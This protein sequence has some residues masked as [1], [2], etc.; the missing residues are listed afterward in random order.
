[1]KRNIILIVIFLAIQMFSTVFAQIEDAKKLM[2]R[3]DYTKAI[4]V[5]EKV[6]EK[7]NDSKKNEAIILLAECYRKKGD[8]FNAKFFYEKAVKINSAPQLQF[9]F[10]QSLRTIG[11]YEQAHEAFLKYNTL[12]PSD[13]RGNIYTS[14]CDSAI[15][16]KFIFPKYEIQNA[17]T[18]NSKFSEFSPTFFDAKLMFVSDRDKASNDEVATK[19]QFGWTG[20][21][22]LNLYIAPIGNK[23]KLNE[24]YSPKIA[25]DFFNNEYHNGP[26]SFS[27]N[28]SLI[29]MNRTFMD[30]VKPDSAHLRTHYLKIVYAIKDGNK[31]SK[32]Q[33]FSMNSDKYSVGHPSISK[34]GETIFFVSDKPGGF[35]GTDIYMCEWETGKWSEATNLGNE[36][37]TFGNEMF[38]YIA[39]NGD[40]YFS[41]DGLPG[42]GSLDIFVTT[43]K[44]GKW[45]TPKNLMA[46]INSSYDDFSFLLNNDYQTGLFS[47]NRPGGAGND[48]IYWFQKII[49]QPTITFNVN[50]GDSTNRKYDSLNLVSD[51]LKYASKVDTSKSKSIS[52]YVPLTGFVKDKLTNKP[53]EGATIFLLNKEQKQVS[54]TKSNPDGSFSMIVKKNSPSIIKAM[55]KGYLDDYDSIIIDKNYN[56]D[57][58]RLPHNL[59]LDKLETEK[60]FV[61]ENIYYD[62]DKWNIRKD[63][64]P[65]LNNLIQI[66][67]DNPIRIELASHT[68]CRGRNGYNDTLSQKRAT[69][70]VRYI[71]SHGIKESRITPIGYGE[72]KLVNECKDGVQCSEEKHQQNRRTEFKIKSWEI[73][74]YKNT[75]LSQY[76][77]GQLI[78]SRSFPENF[79][80]ENINNKL[81]EDQHQN[82]AHLAPED[83]SYARGDVIN[84][85]VEQKF[86]TIQVYAGR[87][88]APKIILNIENI[89]SC[90]GKD[91][92]TRYFVGK[93][94][95]EEDATKEI[96][97][98]IKIGI[99]DA[100]VV[101]I[102]S[103][104]F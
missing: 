101:Q 41:S 19:N 65:I 79:F 18:L 56:Q 3:Y 7:N 88:K 32:F 94:T 104:C 82:N 14:F 27:K 4:S 42:F 2:S 72:T 92:I 81:E 84:K 103:L 53:I 35:G 17:R 74:T 24:F 15:Q 100:F 28:D 10:A 64:E 11:E 77:N 99:K 6:F 78:D 83:I 46:P 86:Y 68:D 22:Y 63:A 102:E 69:S 52:D 96:E 51:T 33:P 80:N 21:G 93:Y 97:K 89:K 9:Y 91:G 57:S 75:D 67:K 13:P 62:Y 36:I 43:Q 8:F 60:S 40:L 47:S 58:F 45:T 90:I 29:Y 59:E 61:L 12:N 55:L 71:V 25:T 49:Q 50:K 70:A 54:I 30:K 37:N 44:K 73:N 39:D 95:H 85:P 38:P 87:Y 26:I 66:M 1:M 76:Q 16:W 5:L 98:Y 34:D 48:D 20:S 23:D 31:W